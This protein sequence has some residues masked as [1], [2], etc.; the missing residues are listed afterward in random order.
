MERIGKFIKKFDI[1]FINQISIIFIMG[2]WATDAVAYYGA[3]L[4]AW[5]IFNNAMLGFT[6]A[7]F[8]Y[9]FT[10]KGW[11]KARRRDLD[12]ARK[13]V[14]ENVELLGLL[15][16]ARGLLEMESDCLERIKTLDCLI[17]GSSFE[18]YIIRK[19]KAKD[20]NGE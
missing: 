9:S 13:V 18:K 19:P 15:A 2:V 4:D 5:I 7:A 6:I 20:S 1:E 14:D 17:E 3:G 10:V 12:L 8:A 16:E 11:Y